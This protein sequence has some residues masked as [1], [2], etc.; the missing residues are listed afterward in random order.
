MDRGEIEVSHGGPDDHG[1]VI[2]TVERSDELRYQRGN[3]S[4]VGTSVEDITGSL[5]MYGHGTSPPAAWGLS[6]VVFFHHVGKSAED[7]FVK[8]EVRIISQLKN[9]GKRGEIAGG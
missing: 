8:R 5:A 3:E 2:P 4:G 1:E 7:S 6:R 9:E